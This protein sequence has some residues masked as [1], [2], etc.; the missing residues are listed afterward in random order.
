MLVV[1]T[2]DNLSKS[3]TLG[4]MHLI[5]SWRRLISLLYL[6]IKYEATSGSWLAL[7]ALSKGNKKT[8]KAQHVTNYLINTKRV[9]MTNHLFAEVMCRAISWIWAVARQ[10]AETPGSYRSWPCKMPISCFLHFIQF[11]KRDIFSS[12]SLIS[13]LPQMSNFCFKCSLFFTLSA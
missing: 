8:S 3:L 1:G 10:I 13:V 4:E 6:F 2:K 12:N 11:N 9:Q 5:I 7:P